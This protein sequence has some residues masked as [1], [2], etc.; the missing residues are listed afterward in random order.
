MS[1]TPAERR[2]AAATRRRWVTL[3][4]VVAV[5]GVLIAAL[6]LWQSWSDRRTDAQVRQDERRAA[7]A[8][9]AAGRRHIGLIATD[10][11]GDTL[12][13][14]GV[15]CALQAT[16]LTFPSALNVP[17]RSTVTVHEID[18]DWFAKP[19]LAITDGGDD[20]R[21]GR[22]PVLIESGCQDENGERGERAIY[23]IAYRIHPRLLRG[24]AVEVRGLVLREAVDGSRA[25]RRLDAAWAREKP[26]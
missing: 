12:S 8:Q 2:E 1:E 3:A 26:A 18:A 25:K 15:A 14:K 6:T 23:D 17:P 4:E 20:R 10:A 22:M 16:T 11:G 19:L 13:F 5:A 7:Q 24:R 21:E 9:A